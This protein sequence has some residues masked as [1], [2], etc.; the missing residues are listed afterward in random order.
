MLK[1]MRLVLGI[2]MK[3]IIFC[4]IVV[5]LLSCCFIGCKKVSPDDHSGHRPSPKKTTPAVEAWRLPY[6]ATNVKVVGQY[7]YE[8]DYDGKRF[9]YSFRTSGGITELREVK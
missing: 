2:K 1:Y 5:M 4:G 6:G 3:K 8:F 9:L 7:W